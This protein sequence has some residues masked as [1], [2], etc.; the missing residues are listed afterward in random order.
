MD[1]LGFLIKE[2]VHDPMGLI[3]LIVIMLFAYML[4]R[5]HRSGGDSNLKS[6]ISDVDGKPSIHKIGQLTALVLSTWL[7][8]YLA[9]QG[10][11]NIEYFGSYMGVWAGAQIADKWMDGRRPP[12]SPPDPQVT[13]SNN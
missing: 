11:M 12:Q 6:V 5:L 3:L 8:V 9:L 13:P 1:N 4:L 2:A 10:Q 7:L